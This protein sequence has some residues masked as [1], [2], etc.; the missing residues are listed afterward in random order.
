MD[1][2]LHSPDEGE[3]PSAVPA[4]KPI[5]SSQIIGFKR[6]F[7]ALAHVLYGLIAIILVAT[8]GLWWWSGTDSSLAQAVRLG[9]TCCGQSLQALTIEQA[10]GSLRSGGNI[11]RAVWQQDGL[12]VEAR[13]IT[14]AWQPWALLDG[15]L[16]LDRLAFDSVHINDQRPPAPI[17]AAGPPETLRLPLRVSLDRFSIGTLGWSGPAEK[18]ALSARDVAGRYDF[19]GTR[20]ALRLTRAQVASGQYSGSATLTADSPLT[21]RADLKGAL[22]VAI[23]TAIPT[24]S[25]ASN[26]KTNGDKNQ[27]AK[28]PAPAPL[29][30]T[31]DATATGA[32]R[33]LQ[34]NAALQLATGTDPLGQPRQPRAK[35]VATVTPWAAQPFSGLDA[36]FQD[37]D[38]AAFL[39]TAPHTLL[40]GR[41]TVQPLQ[42]RPGSAPAVQAGDV[43]AQLQLT[44]G[45]AGPLDQQRLPLEKLDATGQWQHGR[46]MLQ[47]LKALG[48]GGELVASGEWTHT[49]TAAAGAASANVSGQSKT[50]VPPPAP[51]QS[52]KLQAT[53]K[54]INPAKLHS[55]LAALPLD[56]QAAVQS[57]GQAIGFDASVA[58]AK[59]ST[60]SS[61]QAQATRPDDLLRQLRQLRLQSAQATG[62]WL[63]APQGATL[64]LSALRV[65][66]DDA[67]LSGQLQAQLDVNNVA[68]SGAGKLQFTAPGVDARLD[69]DISQTSGAGGVSINGKDAAK[70][71]RWLQKIPAMP[72]QLQNAT[73][74]GSAAFTARW[75]GGWQDPSLQAQLAVPSLDW[76]MTSGDT[77]TATTTTPS[78]STSAPLASNAP[79]LKLRGAQATLS[80]R[81]SQAQVS[82]QGQLESGEQ[83]FALQLVMDAG[84][85]N[86]SS[87]SAPSWQ[88][89]LKQLKLSAQDPAL[90]NGAW[91]LATSSPVTFKWTPA[92]TPSNAT[93]STAGKAK[94]SVEGGIESKV[95]SG[96]F[97]TSAG[98]A[99]LTSP[100]AAIAPTAITNL[101]SASALAQTAP[102]TALLTWQPVR[103]QPGAF[104]TAGKLTG[105]PMAWLTV[106]AG[107]QMASMGLSGNL[108]FDADWDARLTDTLSLKA[109]LARSSGDITLQPEAAQVGAARIAAGIKQ[110]RLS[111]ESI[112]DAVTLALRWDSERAGSAEGQ[113][114]TSL[115]RATGADQSAGDM[116]LG[117]WL[118]PLNAPLAGQLRAQLPRVGVWSALAPPGWRVR[119]SLA[120]NINIA[121]TRAAPQLA[122]DLQANDLALRSVVDGIEF[123]G[124]RLRAQLDG[125][126]ML[127]QEFTLQGA[128]PKGAGGTLAAQGEARWQDGQPQVVMT[129]RLERLRASIRTDRQITLSG[130]L[131]ASLQGQ[132]SQFGGTL[133][134]D[135]A[136]IVL[137]E[138]ST[139]T[140]GDDVV[141]RGP[142]GSTRG[143]VPEVK[144]S[145][146]QVAPI[147]QSRPLLRLNVALD[148]GEDFRVQGKGIDTLV[149]G[150]L[151]LSGESLTEPRL[152]GTL[153]TFG[154]QY[155]AYG[156]RLDVER[157]LLRFTGSVDNPTLDILAIRPNLSQR[158]GVQILGTALLPRVRL[159]AEP[160]LPDAEKL[161]WLVLGQPLG[162]GGGQAALLQQAALALFGNKAGGMS[163]GLAASLGLDDLSF[164]GASSNADG[165]TNQSAVTLGKRFS[166]NFYASYER[167]VSGALGTLYIFYDLSKRFTIRAQAGQQSAVDLIFT[168]PYD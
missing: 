108:V 167:T 83:R 99:V 151:S 130:N 97:E 22:S 70:A 101:S 58:A 9:Q 76:R 91:Q 2:P 77:A 21:L 117:G 17:P 139:P 157:G 93:A 66:S 98:Q 104:T 95:E 168:V 18:V 112:G 109:S 124:G 118:W 8:A 155:K 75:Q 149:R 134:V 73:A 133:R 126:R 56:G 23:P 103:W 110:A 7:K 90:G 164:R 12:M 42:S 41:A 26:P 88:G 152:V 94:L 102:A 1:T 85:K 141:V 123:G 166:R 116:A 106:L 107:P 32:L 6:F 156:Q 52:W 150:T 163:G 68:R 148:M 3:R 11:G 125:T 158:V 142:A 51:T 140:L 147:K 60:P 62:S 59:A 160:E 5:R 38:I 87:S 50:S 114:K 113:L 61:S 71:L 4:T 111:L 80:G 72:V 46:G 13:G 86:V 121:G 45:L 144:V 162:A 34:V 146:V 153:N 31:F 137:P 47:T 19:D 96:L 115:K 40:T 165:T 63:N 67:E 119:G 79:T 55:Q 145:R 24:A 69:G 39:A 92:T 105:L 138:E 16:Q 161:S 35:L 143:S 65:R 64:V 122:G 154:G 100:A 89:V 29:A 37:L 10:S 25:P 78:T 120:A 53:L 128:G 49:S 159:Y 15:T 136:R 81:L 48:A 28:P 135:Q 14:L 57:Q 30:L 131:Q 33:A 132:L 74:V 44:N 20:H 54:N 82:A 27:Q 43:Q 127:I 36:D 129:A 84:R